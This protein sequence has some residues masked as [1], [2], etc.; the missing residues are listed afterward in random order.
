MSRNLQMKRL[1]YSD[2]EEQTTV[3]FPV[4]VGDF[5][6]ERRGFWVVTLF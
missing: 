4:V 3:P 5:I 2:A 6:R 1:K